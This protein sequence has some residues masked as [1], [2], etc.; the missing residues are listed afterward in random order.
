MNNLNILIVEDESLVALELSNNIQNHGF[1]VVDYVTTP[2][3]ATEVFQKEKINLILMDIN[4]GDEMDGIDLYKSFNTRIPIIYLTAY[5]DEKTISKAVETDP[6]G[7]LIK[8]YNEN[9]L[10]AL[11]KLATYKIHNNITK[12]KSGESLLDIGE[13]YF[14]NIEENQLYFNDMYIKLSPK[15]VSLFKLLIEARGDVV[16]FNTIE[17]VLWQDKVPSASSI[18]TLIYRLR[19]KLQYKLITT[20]QHQGIKLEL[21]KS[22]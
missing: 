22:L 10:L 20:E 17:N 21:V 6:L 8:P 13:G 5:Q 19:G 11:L 4:L 12:V 14:Y 7:Y 16:N 18:R 1:N 2:K 15:E 3:M 9:E